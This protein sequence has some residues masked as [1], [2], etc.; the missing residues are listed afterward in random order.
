MASIAAGYT[1]WIEFSVRRRLPSAQDF[2]LG[3]A[4]DIIQ[5][6]LC[7]G[8][9]VLFSRRWYRYHIPMAIAIKWYQTFYD[10]E[11]DHCGVIVQDKF[12][13][14]FLFET[15]PFAGCRLRPFD[16]R[17]LHSQAHQIVVLPI[18]PRDDD[19]I[20]QQQQYIQQQKNSKGGTM[21]VKL[22]KKTETLQSKK[23]ITATRKELLFNFAQTASNAPPSNP[24]FDAECIGQLKRLSTAL[25]MKVFPN[26]SMLVKRSSCV[27]AEL[28]ITSLSCLGIRVQQKGEVHPNRVS[29]VTVKTILNRDVRLILDDTQKEK[30][31]G[32]DIMIRTK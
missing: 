8:D 11:Y 25:W 14:P 1:A 32:S 21:G 5:D 7:S 6:N 19:D 27:N 16:K 13:N 24:V 15:L 9:V 22:P 18:V 2:S 23:S 20:E 30:S 28:F 10:T 3:S 29:D 31:L 17:I 26:N 12:G 4:D